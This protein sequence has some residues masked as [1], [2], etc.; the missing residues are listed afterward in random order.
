MKA[1]TCN[2]LTDEALVQMVARGDS[3]AFTELY[4]RYG[5]KMLSYFFRMLYKDKARAEDQTQ[6]LFLKLVKE[7]HRFDQNK[8][9]STWLYSVAHNMCKNEY[10]KDEVRMKHAR[11]PQAQTTAMQPDG[12]DLSRFRQAL[13][14]CLRKL[15]EEKKALFTL[16]FH[17]QLTIPQIGQVLQ[18]AEGTVKSRLFYLLKDLKEELSV[19]KN[20]H[21]Y[22]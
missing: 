22:P 6:E 7:A 3:A 11:E 4:E 19:F 14:D 16:R 1:V 17:E 13:Q 5:Q 18:L 10:R 15:P 20:I 8:S 2:L 9:F 12:T 21:Q